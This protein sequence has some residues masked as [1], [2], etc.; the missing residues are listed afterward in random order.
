MERYKTL[1]RK[2][3]L[4]IMS[5]NER[6]RR[7]KI[8]RLEREI[9]AAKAEQNKESKTKFQTETVKLVFA[10]Y[11]R[12]LKVRQRLLCLTAGISRKQS[13]V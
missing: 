9:V 13:P 12:I 11:F 6:R 4:L 2:E 3:K 5:K 10:I 8:E 1:T 7:K